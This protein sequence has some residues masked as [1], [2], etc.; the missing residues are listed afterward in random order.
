MERILIAEDDADL[1]KLFQT[2]LKKEGY[3]VIPVEDG[4]QALRYLNREYVDMII[5]D[6]MMPNMDGYELIRAVRNAGQKTPILL[7]TAK[8]GFDD[9]RMGFSLGTDDYMVKPVNMNELVLRVQALIR[10]SR[11]QSERRQTFG[12]MTMEMDS[13]TVTV[14]EES[15]VLPQKEFMLLYKLLNSPGKTFTR[16]QLM[17]EIWGSDSPSDVRTVDVHVNRLRERFRDLPDYEIVTVRG[18][19]YKIVHHNA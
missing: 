4:V 14:N 18:L 15:Q 8:E 19:G 3:E 9:M 17:D 5:S 12:S 2:V 10:R 16:Q 1:L 11:M 7:I 13:M 6:I